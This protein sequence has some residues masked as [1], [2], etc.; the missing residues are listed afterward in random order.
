MFDGWFGQ[1]WDGN[2]VIWDVFELAFCFKSKGNSSLCEHDKGDYSFFLHLTSTV[3]VVK[4]NDVL[5]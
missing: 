2:F 3:F 1:V 4:R 5:L